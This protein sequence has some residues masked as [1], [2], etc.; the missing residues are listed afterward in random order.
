MFTPGTLA[1]TAVV[2][3]LNTFVVAVLFRYF[4]LQLRTR[5]GVG[6]MTLLVLPVALFATTAILTGILGLGGDVGGRDTVLF[7][8]FLSPSVIGIAIDLFLRQSPR[9]DGRSGPP[10]KPPH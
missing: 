1:G 5:W 6:V 4:R 8:A 3:V 10:G 7:V 9:E 2:F